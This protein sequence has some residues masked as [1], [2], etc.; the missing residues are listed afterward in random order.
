MSSVRLLYKP[1]PIIRVLARQSGG[2]YE[3]RLG[4]YPFRGCGDVWC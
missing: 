2:N 1:R 3:P 4:N